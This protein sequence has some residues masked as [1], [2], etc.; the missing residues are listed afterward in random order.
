MWN[1]TINL[2]DHLIFISPLNPLCD[3]VGG[4]SGDFD[5]QLIEQLININDYNIDECLSQTSKS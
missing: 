5:V 2:I 1:K 3:Y 4:Y